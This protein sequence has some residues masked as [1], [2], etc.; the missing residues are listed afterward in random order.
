MP[1]TELPPL[2]DLPQVPDQS[3]VVC[4]PVPYEATTSYRRGT[5]K[6]PE[7]IQRASVQVDLWDADTEDAWKF[8]IEM[9]PVDPRIVALNDE[10][11]PL[12][13]QV[14]EAGGIVDDATR[15]AAERVNAMSA[16][17]NRLVLE[18]TGQLIDEGRI[19]GIIG[20]DH[21][22]AFGAIEVAAS[23][24][25]GLG[26]LQIDAHADLRHAYQGFTWSHASV[27]HNVVRR[28]PN[29]RSLVQVGIRDLCDDEWN[30][31][32]EREHVHT[33]LQPR[34]AWRLAGGDAWLTLA[35]HMIDPLPERVWVSFDIDGLDPTLCPN[36]GTPVP[37]GLSWDQ[38]VILIQA[39]VESGRTIVGFDLCEVAPG[40][41]T[42]DSWDAIVGAR[43]L[44]KL[45]CWSI[46]S[47]E[48]R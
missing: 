4:V 35:R 45:A 37:G 42:G 3:R 44:Y 17:V 22:V 18:R 9:D 30:L 29:V 12:A 15:E 41:G 6:G 25:P 32:R 34:V 1:D 33:W 13:Q 48:D 39:L 19:P 46:C 28:V 23:R 21:S 10:A 7:A 20:G 16:E 47:H 43:M 38:A 24:R 2:F 27:M 11:C 26:V 31:T 14:I 8:G 36:T 40:P 5:A